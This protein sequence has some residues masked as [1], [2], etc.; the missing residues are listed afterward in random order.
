MSSVIVTM[1]PIPK[2]NRS[3]AEMTEPS[4]I[5]RSLPNSG[6]LIC[7][8]DNDEPMH[9]GEGGEICIVGSQVTRG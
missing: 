3:D 7:P 2:T 5:G 6:L 8:E 9:Y 1:E 4:L